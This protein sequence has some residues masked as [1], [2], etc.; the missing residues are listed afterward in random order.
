MTARGKRL[1]ALL[2]ALALAAV[3]ADVA[4]SAFLLDEGLFLGRPLPPFGA[5]NHPR[6]A[7]WLARQQESLARGAEPRTL[8]VFDRELGWTARP[9]GSTPGGA[10]TVN[11]AGARGP[12]EYAPEPPAGTTRVLTFGDSF[13]WCSEVADAETWQAQLEALAPDVEAPNLG[14]PSYGTDQA[15][16]RFRRVAPGWRHHVACLGILVENAGRNVN[17]Y[18]PLY[19]PSA[20]SPGTKP[21]FLLE[22]G[23]LRLLPQPFATRAELVAAVADGSVLERTAAHEHWRDAVDLGPA[24]HSSLLRL[25]HAWRAYDRRRP[26]RLWADPGG[27]PARVTVAIAE[28]FHREALALGARRAL[29]LVFPREQELIDLGAGRGRSWQ[30]LLDALAASGVSHVDL[31]TVLLEHYAAWRS[32]TPEPT[33]SGGHLSPAANGLVAREVA[34]WLREHP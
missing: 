16:L 13:T 7:H 26:A 5:V 17:R 3:L 19:Y 28:A 25:F 31:S 1:A 34:A 27:E 4:I 29:V 11:A 21:R 18:R 10:E 8:A 15:L 24:R 12:R 6:Q 23:E 20:G 30:P 32:G 9:S 33:F 2:A 14:V 22:G